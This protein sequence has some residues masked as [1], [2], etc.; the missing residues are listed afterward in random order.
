MTSTVH[1]PAPAGTGCPVCADLRRENAGLL[2]ELAE[3]RTA[4]LVA[5]KVASRPPDTTAPAT[6]AAPVQETP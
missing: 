2:T 5:L 4:V 1:T 6:A 3:A